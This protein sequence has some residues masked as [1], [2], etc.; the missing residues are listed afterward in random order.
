VPFELPIPTSL[1]SAC[2]K[3]KIREK[4]AREPPHVTILRRTSAWRIDLRT[5][6]FMDKEPDPAD[7]PKNLLNY[8]RKEENWKILCNEW[9][10][11]YP[12]NPVVGPDEANEDDIDARQ[13]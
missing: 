10:R 3:V 8:V 9:N 6:L 7:I 4:E 1:R 5:G 12:A 11:K 2:W 13:D